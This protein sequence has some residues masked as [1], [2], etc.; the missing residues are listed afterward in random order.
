MRSVHSRLCVLL[1]LLS[2][3]YHLFVQCV[4]L[5]AVREQVH[6]TAVIGVRADMYAD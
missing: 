6:C 4:R 5:A 1:E 2:M 3:L